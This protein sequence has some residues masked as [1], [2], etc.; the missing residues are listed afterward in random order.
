M[1]HGDVFAAVQVW[2]PAGTVH[3][4]RRMFFGGEV[5]ADAVIPDPPVLL[6]VSAQN[7]G[8]SKGQEV[9]IRGVAGRKYS[10][11]MGWAPIGHCGDTG[12][13]AREVP[14]I[15]AFPWLEVRRNEAYPVFT[16]ASTDQK[17]PWPDAKAGDQKGQINAFFRWK[18]VEDSEARF[19]MELWLAGQ[20]KG[21]NA[22]ATADVSFRRLQKFQVPAG[23]SCIWELTRGGA[24]AASG[25]I[26]P[27]AAGLLTIPKVTVTTAAATVS[28]KVK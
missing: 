1:R 15:V 8:W 11:I 4:A 10:L 23:K 13:Y 2:V 22:Q 6:N 16:G 25:E 17:P 24:E 26:R 20:G 7:D 14:Q 5:P 27:D 9:L 3:V 21:G 12:V 18:N 28:L 19:A